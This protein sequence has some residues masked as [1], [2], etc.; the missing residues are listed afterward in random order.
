VPNFDK[1]H[2]ACA[3]AMEPAAFA[4]TDNESVSVLRSV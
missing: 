4:R 2:P 1:R 3:E